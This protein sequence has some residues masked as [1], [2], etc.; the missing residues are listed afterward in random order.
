MFHCALPLQQFIAF[1]SGAVPPTTVLFV[2]PPDDRSG[3]LRRHSL[4]PTEAVGLA[5]ALTG[6]QRVGVGSKPKPNVL[7]TDK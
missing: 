5:P 6:R 7:K 4:G 3:R 1:S 2:P